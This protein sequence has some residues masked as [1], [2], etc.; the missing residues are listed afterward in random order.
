MEVAHSLKYQESSAR[1]YRVILI[2]EDFVPEV[3][4]SFGAGLTC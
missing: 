1:L 3:F 2:P 4:S